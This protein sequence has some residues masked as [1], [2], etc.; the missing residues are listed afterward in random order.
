[1]SV[2]FVA[3]FLPELAGL[4][5]EVIGVGLVDAAIGA[6]RVVASRKASGVVLL[7]TAGAYPGSGLAIGDV[8]V[9]ESIVLASPTGALVTDAMSAAIET[10]AGL[11]ARFAAARVDAKRARVATTLA[12]TTDDDIARAL[13]ASTR[14][15]VE[16]LEAFAVARVCALANVPFTAV[17]GVANGVGAR[18]RDE[19]RANHE[20]A[21]AACARLIKNRPTLP[22]RA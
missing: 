17:L 19:W 4:E 13:E 10:D 6:A 18:G 11:V 7:G 2:V 15:H 20:S 21:S 22:S 3:A 1:M 5:G 16:H 12:I 9:A 14:A 8:V